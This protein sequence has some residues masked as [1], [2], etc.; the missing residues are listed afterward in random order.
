MDADFFAVLAVKT[1]K[2]SGPHE[3]CAQPHTIRGTKAQRL[4]LKQKPLLFGW[5][6]L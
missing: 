5:D 6:S 4:S 3:I 2:D 1:V